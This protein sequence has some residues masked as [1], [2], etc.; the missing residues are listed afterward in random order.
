M[1][2]VVL[3]C[4]ENNVSLGAI[5]CLGEAGYRPICYC[6]G[7]K[8]KYLLSSKYVGEGKVF[9]TIEDAFEQLRADFPDTNEKP[10]LLT[11]PDP[12]AHIIDMHKDEMD[13]KFILMSAGKAGAIVHWMDKK[14]ISEL[15]QKH[16]LIIPWTIE[17][18]KGDSVPD[19]LDY[20]VFTKSSSTT[21]GGK[22]DESVC[23]TKAELDERVKTM[24]SERFLVMKYI[25]KKKEIN[26]YGMSLKGRIYIDY[27]D[28]RTRFTTTGFG[29]Y[30]KFSPCLKDE[31]YDKIVAMIKATGYEGLFD[32]EFLQGVDG[33]MYFLE[34][35]FR[36]DGTLYRLSPGVNLPAEWCKW[37]ETPENKLPQSLT[38][39]KKHFTGMSEKEDF[40]NSVLTGMVNPLKWF[41]QFCT[42][43]KHM[44]INIRDPKPFFVRLFQK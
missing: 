40:Q 26:Y 34:V 38:L 6:F 15:A 10:V 9:N 14:N 33:N 23:R 17:M 5:R 41:Y 20:P 12:P 22:C 3:F 27:S 24:V 1:K 43:D 31:L 7:H 19:G 21:D 30:Q 36:L 42:A 28:E 2:K 13:K 37:V 39:K 16:G 4:G 29:N 8:C 18:K 32:V 25:Q 44:L 11:I 35:N